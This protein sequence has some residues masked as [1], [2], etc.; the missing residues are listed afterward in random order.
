MKNFDIRE[1]SFIFVYWHEYIGVYSR[2]TLESNIS[3]DGEWEPIGE[4]VWHHPWNTSWCMNSDI[5]FTEDDLKW[6]VQVEKLKDPEKTI[7]RI[8]NPY[9]SG[10]FFYEKVRK[11]HEEMGYNLNS[12]LSW[13]DES[14]T[15]WFVFDCT[16]LSNV[17]I[18]PRLNGT[19]SGIVM[20][21]WFKKVIGHGSRDDKTLTITAPTG[22]Y[23]ST[24][25]IEFN[26]A[27]QSTSSIDNT[28]IDYSSP[29]KVYNLNGLKIECSKDKLPGGLY[30]IRQGNRVEK[31][32][33]R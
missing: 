11:Y 26:D 25:I 5:R 20:D 1:K 16:D 9:K 27:S 6:K 31:R 23:P 21:R 17:M 15:Y 33:V 19:I 29:Y 7:Y 2:Y 30:I 28:E 8:V 3:P 32:A 12:D 10:T 22:Y 18:Y 4:A 13:V 24:Y 14:D